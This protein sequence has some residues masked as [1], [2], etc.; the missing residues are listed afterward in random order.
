MD[1][2]KRFMC[3][4]S[5]AALIVLFFSA[6][7]LAATWYVS[8]SGNDANPGTQ[9][10]PFKTINKAISVA[11][12]GDEIVIAAGTYQ[13]TG[14]S[15]R[16]MFIDKSLKL[17]GAGKGQTIVEFSGL[18]HGLEIVKNASYALDV[19]IEGM[20][21]T[22]KSTNSYSAQWAVIVGETGG[23]FASI[24][25]KDV[26]IAYAQARNLHFDNA[27]YTYVNIEDCEIHHAGS[28]GCSARGTL[29]D[30]NIKNSDFTYNGWND[31]EHGIGF[32]VDIPHT[33]IALHITGGNFSNNTAKGM[34]L[35]TVNNVV[36]DGATASNNAGYSSG[37]HGI[38]IWE[39]NW[40]DPP[41]SSSNHIVIKNSVLNDNS[42]DGILIGTEGTCSINDV[43]VQ[44]C[45]MNG[46][47]RGGVFVYKASSGSSISGVVIRHNSFSSNQWAVW[48]NLTTPI[49]ASGNW[50]GTGLTPSQVAAK[51][52]G[53]VDYTPYLASGTDMSAAIGFQP[54]LSDLYVTD[55]GP[56]SG[57]TGRLMEG[58]G[59]VSGSTVHLTAGTY[60]EPAQVDITKN[61]N[62]VGD[63][64]SSTTVKPGFNT[65]NSSSKS[66]KSDAFIYVDPYATV[67]IKN[68]TLDC[69]GKQVAMG[70]Q[71]R[72]NLV[73]ENCVVK[74]VRYAQYFGRGIVFFGGSANLVKNT[75]FSNIE[76]IGVHI[77]GSVMATNP[78]ADVV[79]CTYTGKGDGDWLDYGVEF[80]AGGKGKVLNT[81]ITACTG[82][83]S[84]GWTSAGIAV[85]DYYGPGTEAEIYGC[86]L[87]GN[88]YG[89]DVGYLTTDQSV[90]KIHDNKIYGNTDYGVSSTGPL[91]Y[92]TGNWWGSNKG[93]KDV[94]GTLEMPENP[95]ATVA[96]MLNAAPS[97]QLGDKVSD[98][99][100]YYPWNDLDIPI[101]A[102]GPYVSPANGVALNFTTLPAGGGHVSIKRFVEP[103]YG[104]P[105][106]P[107]G[108]LG[109]MYL[110]I[111]SDMPNYSFTVTVTLNDLPSGIG[112]LSNIYYYNEASS[113]WV[114]IG[115]TYADVAPSG[116]GPGDTFTFTT[117][118]FT[119]F[120]ILNPG[121]ALPLIITDRYPDDS[122]D[123]STIPASTEP[124]Q[125]WMGT[126]DL[127]Y[128]WSWSYLG[129]TLEV[130]PMLI[131]GTP[132]TGANIF[133]AD[134]VLNIDTT[135]WKAYESDVS[136]GSLW[137][138]NPVQFFVRR[139]AGSG[140]NVL[141]EMH[142]AITAPLNPE[143]VSDAVNALFRLSVRPKVPW[144]TPITFADA[145]LRNKMNAAYALDLSDDGKARVY[146]GDVVHYTA[147][148]PVA[149]DSSRGDGLVDVH[150]LN[151]WSLPYFRDVSGIVAPAPYS[152]YRLKYD[153]GPTTTNYVDGLPVPD[154]KIDFEDLVIFAISYGL[155]AGNVYPKESPQVGPVS[156][157]V[158]GEVQSAGTVEVP[159]VLSG[160]GGAVKAFSLTVDYDTRSLRFEGARAGSLL[161]DG[162]F[163]RAKDEGGRL[164]VDGAVLDG[165]AAGSGELVVLSFSASSGSPDGVS[166]TG[167]L[168]RDARN[169]SIGTRIEGASP[170]AFVLG[171]NYPNPFSASTVV[172]FGIPSPSQVE[173]A[174]FDGLGR[175]VTT[176]ASGSMDRGTYQVQWNGR[177]DRGVAVAA[178]V[179]YLRLTG[180]G[181]AV[182]R[183]IHVTR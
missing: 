31:A 14:W 161:G 76:R 56:Q 80:G 17:T 138:S 5:V 63:A 129:C 7:A 122:F 12:A 126:G 167:A 120:V 121:A 173:L 16:D 144:P 79:G 147:G 71:S 47:G 40:P 124:W 53:N 6:S 153:I 168:L 134:V 83:A 45:V 97:G 169:R 94:S 125:S 51:I 62:I 137:G 136:L 73:V 142:A 175:K 61:V 36:I 146:L 112:A 148:P 135:M 18:Q 1:L 104:Y 140:S 174:V 3:M 54:D 160:N 85:S 183:A 27:T 64:A 139:T 8:P 165:T 178:G 44:N 149:I 158:A 91:V 38:C 52:N 74:N 150:D 4:A 10:Q 93:P 156:L 55:Q 37:S 157:A 99:V 181:H 19:W 25:F 84:G 113:T 24:V 58:I 21:F 90:V 143:V 179:Y 103:P 98:N 46:N 92:A 41:S 132:P 77:R 176:L 57:T 127:V 87:T 15:W 101:T 88:T 48:S 159:I 110:V 11:S 123:E 28:W 67:S 133:A 172:R 34:N 106:A 171:Q 102:T 50:W 177:D 39:W 78:I 180:G 33:V 108:A 130:I 72:G 96:Q 115:G 163:V 49:D 70:I 82:F 131:P 23:T 119:P 9:A 69:G 164:T 89:V 68:I 117:N 65:T 75:T 105:P 29:T 60:T 111:T 107:S 128:D 152:A 118:H 154:G 86:I 81:T 22:K 42:T 13:E 170:C 100:D 114:P 66:D 166:L 20:T 30:F 141:L 32:D 109:G 2:F 43:T 95:Q 116:Y 162:A 182:Q 26:E 151:K 155:S 35:K 59:M 145:K